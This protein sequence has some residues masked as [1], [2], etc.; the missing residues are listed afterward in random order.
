MNNKVIYKGIDFN[1][2]LL[3]YYK[4]LDLT[5][6]E[7]LVALMSNYL[8]EAGNLIITNELLELKLSLSKK[9]ID[10]SLSNLMNKG[11]LKYSKTNTGLIS[12]L[13][14]LY[15]KLISLFVKKNTID[16][17]RRNLNDNLM[18]RIVDVF[19]RELNK[20]LNTQDIQFIEKWIEDNVPE[21]IIINSFK[22]A[23]NENNPY[24]SYVDKIIKRRLKEKENE[25]L[26]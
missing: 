14:S 2:L 11:Y 21:D 9:E 18:Y 20:N 25:G 1:N 10:D 15:E 13:D 7:L 23:L 5:S 4:E 6:N 24:L 3:E 26:F 19:E 8:L 12:S 17:E 16:E 22:D